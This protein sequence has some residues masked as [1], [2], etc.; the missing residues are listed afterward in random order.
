MEPFD[1]DL[2][3]RMD[4]QDEMIE[5]VKKYLIDAYVRREKSLPDFVEEKGSNML[6]TVERS[7]YLRT[8]DIL[9]MEH[10]DTMTHLRE[11]VS[12]RGYGQRDPLIEY[13]Q[14]AFN[15][16]SVMLNAIG[17]NTV[18]TLFRVEFQRE[19]ADPYMKSEQPK[20]LVTNESQIEQNLIKLSDVKT[21]R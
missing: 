4:T 12:L 15:T 11:A 7:V 14:E 16:F 8:L 5:I 20:N 18:Q 1:F 10:I 17:H 9:W 19:V 6:R 21:K 2:F 3:M 13:K